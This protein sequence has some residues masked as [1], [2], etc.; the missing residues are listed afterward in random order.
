MFNIQPL[1]VILKGELDCLLSL[2]R[3]KR[4]IL[5]LKVF[6]C[7][8]RKQP[9]YRHCTYEVVIYE[10]LFWR[11]ASFGLL[12]IAWPWNFLCM[13]VSV[14]MILKRYDDNLRL[15]FTYVL[16]TWC[17]CI[18]FNIAL[19]TF[20]QLIIVCV[21]KKVYCC[22]FVLFLLVLWCLCFRAG[23]L[24][25]HPVWHLCFL[26]LYMEYVGWWESNFELIY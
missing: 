1:D 7:Y 23:W 22:L 18:V 20:S 3:I 4:C 25:P 16:N 13:Q 14:D 12:F 15:Y 2:H 8:A 9:Y 17:S 26:V 21:I 5:F 6:W 19:I 11:L 10:I 24:S